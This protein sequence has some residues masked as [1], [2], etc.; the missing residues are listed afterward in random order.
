MSVWIRLL[1][2]RLLR[3]RVFEFPSLKTL[4]I[5]TDV[6]KQVLSLKDKSVQELVEI[7]SALNDN[8]LASFVTHSSVDRICSEL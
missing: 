4:L 6:L 2:R 8:V 5:E 1:P 3:R 7:V